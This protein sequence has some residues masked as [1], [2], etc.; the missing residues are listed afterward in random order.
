M[1]IRAASYIEVHVTVCLSICDPCTWNSGR[2][3]ET[4]LY[5]TLKM[6]GEFLSIQTQYDEVIRAV[7]FCCSAT[8][9]QQRVVFLNEAEVLGP[10]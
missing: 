7:F 3:A 9:G 2:P 1:Q 6:K 5:R 4:D 10:I 8:S